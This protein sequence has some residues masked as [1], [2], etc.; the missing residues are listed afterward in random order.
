GSTDMGDVTQAVPGMHPYLSICDPAIAGHSREFTEASGSERGAR[1]MLAA[2]KAL[3]MT[4]VDVMTT[5]D[6]VKQMWDEFR[7]S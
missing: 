7:T 6:L 1:A 3:A 2:A 5:P 4:A